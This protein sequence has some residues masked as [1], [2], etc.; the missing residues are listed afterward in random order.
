MPDARFQ[1]ARVFPGGEG[2]QRM[3]EEKKEDPG[4]PEPEPE[5]DGRGDR[6]VEDGDPARRAG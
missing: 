6:A 1:K 4:D 5:P 3:A 2:R